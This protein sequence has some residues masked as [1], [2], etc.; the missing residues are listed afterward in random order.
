MQIVAATDVGL[1]R[2]RNEDYFVIDRPEALVVVCDGM[3]GHPGGDLASRMTAEEV[4]RFIT[5]NE[6]NE[7]PARVSNTTLRP[8]IPLLAAIFSADN[9]LRRYGDRN[10]E[11][12]GMGTTI[13]AMQERNGAICIAHVGDS[14]VYTFNTGRLAQITRDHSLVAANPECANIA[15]MRNVL[16]RAMGQRD[17]LEV[18]F[19]VVPA[20][21]GDTF[22]LCTD[23]LHNFVPEARIAEILGSAA[24]AEERIAT[25]I[26]EAKKGGGG[27]NITLSLV[28]I[29]ASGKNVTRQMRGVARM[30]GD[31]LAVVLEP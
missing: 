20:V 15:A 12:E 16:T 29:E 17:A 30:Q 7:I 14:R 2:K 25:L 6:S 9:K 10:P 3:G 23:G 28:S 26:E 22:L 11:F 8:F 19:M 1:V 13:V 5:S 21:A 24:P 18:D 31:E 4:H 27:D